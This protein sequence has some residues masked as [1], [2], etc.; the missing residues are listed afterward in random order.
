VNGASPGIVMKAHPKVG[1]FYRQ[2]FLLN[3]AEDS[4]GVLNVNQTVRVPAGTFHHC[5]ETAEVTGLEPGALEDKVYA[6]GIGNVLTVDLVTGDTFP[7]VQITGQADRKYM[8]VCASCPVARPEQHLFSGK[9]RA[10]EPHSSQT[11][12]NLKVRRIRHKLFAGTTS[13]EQR[14]KYCRFAAREDVTPLQRPLKQSFA[15]RRATPC[16]LRCD[17]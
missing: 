1:D 4:A 11:I 15:I 10:S 17:P 13:L 5:L 9:R 12:N 14:L 2:E 8:R 3:T 7:L 16:G 6:P